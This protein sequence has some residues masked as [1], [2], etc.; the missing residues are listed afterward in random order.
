MH[1]DHIL[2]ALLSE[3][4]CMLLACGVCWP[5]GLVGAAGS[6]RWIP[7]STPGSSQVSFLAAVP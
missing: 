7:V 6:Y 2:E 4:K 3:L 1:Q 5:A